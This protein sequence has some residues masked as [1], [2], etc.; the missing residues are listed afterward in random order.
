MNSLKKEEQK[1]KLNYY[2]FDD[3]FGGVI[4]TNDSSVINGCTFKY[5]VYTD[6]VEMR[7]LVNASTVNYLSIGSKRFV[8]EE[9]L[10]EDSLLFE[11]YFELLINGDCKLLLRREMFALQGEED[12]KIYGSSGSTKI[13]EILYIKKGNEPA[14]EVVRSKKFFTNYFSNHELMINYINHKFSLFKSEKSIRELVG[15]YNKI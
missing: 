14:V 9:Y 8:H 12:I 10:T 2:L 7:T 5:N 11:G 4:F 6:Q 3:W 1:S 13:S 15:Y